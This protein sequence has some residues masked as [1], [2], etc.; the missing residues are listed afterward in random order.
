MSYC[1]CM[2]W[3]VYLCVYVCVTVF[4]CVLGCLCMCLCTYACHACMLLCV[5]VF[6]CA[7]F[8]LDLIC[9]C[10]RMCM[11]INVLSQIIFDYGANEDQSGGWMNFVGKALMSSA[12]YLPSNVSHHIPCVGINA[13]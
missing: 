1:V 12:S 2:C 13:K 11:H 8:K 3:C 5:H 7:S 10:L 9:T 4:V 6:V